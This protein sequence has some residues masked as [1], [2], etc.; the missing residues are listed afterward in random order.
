MRKCDDKMCKTESEAMGELQSPILRGM[1]NTHRQT[2]RQP[3]GE[4]SYRNHPAGGSAEPIESDVPDAR[5]LDL[6]FFFS[7]RSGHPH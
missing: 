1:I 7:R 2:H 5:P 3:E 6:F 4:K